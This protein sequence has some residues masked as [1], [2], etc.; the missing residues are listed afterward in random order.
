MTEKPAL[1]FLTFGR[2]TLELEYCF[3]KV[4]FQVWMSKIVYLACFQANLK[5]KKFCS[6]EPE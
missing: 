5:Y 1:L 6:V 3:N 2:L 4:S